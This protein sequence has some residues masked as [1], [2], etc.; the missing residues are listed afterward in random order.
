MA[1]ILFRAFDILK[2]R[3]IKYFDD[4]SG[5]FYVM[6]DD[7]AAGSIAGLILAV[8]ILFTIN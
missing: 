7:V 5:G 8:E 3:P 2:P 6:M 1:F 4:K